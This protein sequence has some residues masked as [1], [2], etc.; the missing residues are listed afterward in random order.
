MVQE[1]CER[2]QVSKL[3]YEV[4]KDSSVTVETVKDVKASALRLGHVSRDGDA[5]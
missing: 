2:G 1:R 4:F 3:R 5:D